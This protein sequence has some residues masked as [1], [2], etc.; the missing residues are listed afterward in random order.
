MKTTKKAT[1]KDGLVILPDGTEYQFWK[2]KNRDVNG[3]SRHYVSWM[4]LGLPRYEATAVTRRAG[5]KKMKT[6]EFGGGFIFQSGNGD[7]IAKAEF[8]HSL[9]L[10]R[11]NPDPRTLTAIAESQID[12]AL[13]S[14][15]AAKVRPGYILQSLA[16]AL[17]PKSKNGVLLR[18]FIRHIEEI[19]DKI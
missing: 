6:K 1:E 16:H 12:K 17:R 3:N 13:E 10:H 14:A 11:P 2:A 18:G 7:L 4:A 5:L 8:F 19:A 15:I 9:G